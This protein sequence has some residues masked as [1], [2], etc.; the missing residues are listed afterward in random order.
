M[1]ITQCVQGTLHVDL[2]SGGS[3]VLKFRFMNNAQ[4]RINTMIFREFNRITLFNQKTQQLGHR[5]NDE[6]TWYYGMTWKMLLKNILAQR[7]AFAPLDTVAQIEFGNSVKK[8]ESDFLPL[9]LYFVL[10]S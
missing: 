7:P 9:W 10:K 1:V 5:L 2:V 3:K 4:N 8:I 6:N